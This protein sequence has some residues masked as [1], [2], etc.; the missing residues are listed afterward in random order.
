MI[1]VVLAVALIFPGIN[2]VEV[3]N[4]AP[5]IEPSGAVWTDD[6]LLFVDDGGEVFELRDDVV[7]DH[8]VLRGSACPDNCDLEGITTRGD[9]I[10]VVTEWSSTLLRI[11]FAD[12]VL[13]SHSAEHCV[14]Y[15][16]T[17]GAEALTYVPDTDEFWIGK[18]ADGRVYVVRLVDGVVECVRNFSVYPH[19]DLS[20]MAYGIDPNGAPWVWAIWDA[21]NKGAILRLDGTVVAEWALPDDS[22]AQE[23]IAYNGH[24]FLAEDNRGVRRYNPWLLMW[25]RP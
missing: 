19:Y 21:Y 22:Q 17:Y 5:N 25:R 15:D 14:G 8:V 18:Q 2:G 12:G 7:T 24:I 11:T 4:D 16:S 1:S 6:S 3:Y 9:E 23:G 10:W 20:G 13:E